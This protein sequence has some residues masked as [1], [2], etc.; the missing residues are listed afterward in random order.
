MR[1]KVDK[2]LHEDIA[3]LLRER[4]HDALSVFAQGIRGIDSPVSRS[5]PH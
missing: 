3:A 2:N 1:F 4:G 5:V